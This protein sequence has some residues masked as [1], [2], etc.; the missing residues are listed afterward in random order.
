M[1]SPGFEQWLDDDSNPTANLDNGEEEDQDDVQIVD[2]G[3]FPNNGNFTGFIEIPLSPDSSNDV[4]YN[5]EDAPTGPSNGN[6]PCPDQDTDTNNDEDT[7]DDAPMVLLERSPSPL[8]IVNY[9]PTSSVSLSPSPPSPMIMTIDADDD[10]SELVNYSPSPPSS[11]PPSPIS[12]SPS[13][14]CSPLEIVQYSPTP[15]TS[16]SISPSP[17]PQKQSRS[18]SPPLDSS[19]KPGPSG[20]LSSIPGPSGFLTSKPGPSGFL[21]S[22]PGPSG[23]RPTTSKPGFFSKSGPSRNRSPR[24]VVEEIY[25]DASSSDQSV[26]SSPS[27]LGS[28]ISHPARC[29]QSHSSTILADDSDNSSDTRPVPR[30]KSRNRMPLP[31]R[32]MT[33]SPSPPPPMQSSPSPDS[34]AAPLSY[35]MSERDAENQG[36]SNSQRASNQQTRIS[37]SNRRGRVVESWHSPFRGIPKFKHRRLDPRRHRPLCRTDI[38]QPVIKLEQGNTPSST[39][40]AHR[41][42]LPNLSEILGE[43]IRCVAPVVPGTSTSDPPSSSFTAR[44]STSD[45][46]SSSFTARRARVTTT[47]LPQN[48][49]QT[50]VDSSSRSSHN[51]YVNGYLDRIANLQKMRR[52]AELNLHSPPHGEVVDLEDGDIVDLEE[53]EPADSNHNHENDADNHQSDTNAEYNFDMHIIG[54]Q[55][56]RNRICH[57]DPLEVM[58]RTRVSENENMERVAFRHRRFGIAA[59]SNAESARPGQSSAT[60]RNIQ[61][62]PQA[63]TGG[64]IQPVSNQQDSHPRIRFVDEINVI[65][66]TVS[67]INP[68]PRLALPRRVRNRVPTRDPETERPI[69]RILSSDPEPEIPIS[70]IQTERPI[71]RILSSDPEPEIPISRIQTERPILRIHSPGPE[72]ERPSSTLLSLPQRSLFQGS[73]SD[74]NQEVMPS[75]YS[76]VQLEQ[77]PTL[78]RLQYRPRESQTIG[79]HQFQ[80]NRAV[81]VARARN[82]PVASTE[83][84]STRIFR[85]HTLRARSIL[86]SSTENNA[87]NAVRSISNRARLPVRFNLN[88]STASTETSASDAGRS[89]NNTVRNTPVAS[90]EAI[91]SP[92]GSWCAKRRR[93]IANVSDRL[94]SMPVNEEAEL[95]PTIGDDDRAVTNEEGF[96]PHPSS[97]NQNSSDI[98]VVSSFSNNMVRV[99]DS[100]A[101]ESTTPNI[102]TS[103]STWSRSLV[104]PITSRSPS[105]V[106]GQRGPPLVARRSRIIPSPVEVQRP[107]PL[108][109]RILSSP[110]EVQRPPSLTARRSRRSSSPVEIE[111]PPP[112]TARRSRRSSSPVEFEGPGPL[113]ARWSRRSSSPAEFEDLPPDAVRRSRRSSGNL[114]VFEGPRP[115]SDR[116]SSSPVEVQRPPPLTAR[117]SSSPVEVEEP[118]PLSAIRSS[119]PVEVQRPPQL[120]ASSSRSRAVAEGSNVTVSFRNN[121]EQGLVLPCPGTSRRTSPVVVEYPGSPDMLDLPSRR[122]SSQRE[123]SSRESQESPSNS[124]HMEATSRESRGPRVGVQFPRMATWFR[125]SSVEDERHEDALTTSGMDRNAALNRGISNRPMRQIMQ[126]ANAISGSIDVMRRTTQPTTRSLSPLSRN[127]MERS[128]SPI[129][130]RPCITAERRRASRTVEPIASRTV[131]PIASR[132]VEPIAA[133]TAEPRSL[134]PRSENMMRRATQPTMGNQ[135]RFPRPL[136]GRAR[137]LEGRSRIARIVSPHPLSPRARVLEA[138][139][140]VERARASRTAEPISVPQPGDILP[141]GQTME[142]RARV[143][144]RQIQRDFQIGEFQPASLNVIE[145]IGPNEEIS[146]PSSGVERIDTLPTHEPIIEQGISNDMV[147]E[148]ADTSPV[149]EMGIRTIREDMGIR[150]RE[151][152]Q[153]LENLT[154]DD[155]TNN[156]RPRE[157][158]EVFQG[159]SVNGSYEADLAE[160]IKRSLEDPNQREDIR[161]E[162]DMEQSGTN[163]DSV[164][165]ET[166]EASPDGGREQSSGREAA[167]PSPGCSHWN[168]GAQEIVSSTSKP[169]G[170]DWQY[171]YNELLMKHLKLIADLQS[172]VE[173]PV[174]FE[175]PRSAPIPCCLMGHVM[176]STC[177]SRSQQCPT[178]RRDLPGKAP[179]SEMCVSHVANHLVD[180]L[181]HPC[182]NRDQG[183]PYEAHANEVTA[184]EADCEYR[185]IK[186]P[187]FRCKKQV[188]LKKLGEH[189]C[190]AKVP[191]HNQWSR[192]ETYP[193]QVTRRMNEDLIHSLDPVRFTFE[194]RPCFLQSMASDD[195]R[196]MFHFVQ[197]CGTREECQR[198]NAKIDIL[199]R[200]GLISSQ[201]CQLIPLDLHCLDDQ[202]MIGARLVMQDQAFLNMLNS[203]NQGGWTFKVNVKI[204]KT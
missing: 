81:E 72:T 149:Q 107:P 144:V 15:P 55:R 131:E 51:D 123:A 201:N 71:L 3:R 118:P 93:V 177:W 77:G 147:E 21:T 10:V 203:D 89:S 86:A 74:D 96:I 168:G 59:R 132:T 44:T 152:S 138:R 98:R 197:M 26:Q 172:S 33:P 99:R 41:T 42:F 11:I 25:S 102:G 34:D 12:P 129:E 186:C 164:L 69:L 58:R 68:R 75:M 187:S 92:N 65:P 200:G 204:S 45:P 180:L 195:S 112:L 14:V 150:I 193:L 76:P 61:E 31:H 160:A 36:Q 122:E 100:T 27:P 173:C 47:T 104:S 154:R 185:I 121:E 108:T 23:F 83:T 53:S 155:N 113:T 127:M 18:P 19:S 105:P 63:H 103:F 163:N 49:H 78:P 64:S 130:E 143:V 140:H 88:P 120:T 48:V 43:G 198:Y 24:Q 8:E 79:R 196:F 151:A 139:A 50:D 1:A 192:I 188:S 116:R 176:C 146:G 85:T 97:E 32:D 87:S 109:A 157:P 9:S 145:D 119:S 46:P 115:L 194:G 191:P 199:G 125:S 52:R 57:D 114:Q 101:S 181:P 124:E 184:H 170:P 117:R 38:S 182:T 37:M 13:P 137:V 202:D 183:C 60:P 190:S 20:F 141:L 110:V 134:S 169:P 128:L 136:V 70:R 159:G 16:I 165:D 82:T 35:N 174:C 67:D 17:P 90:T 167:S 6:E 189:I 40:A 111:R 56:P 91:A 178:C 30:M 106:F 54:S 39:E 171:K 22:K 66:S 4:V 142:E 126:R 156:E 28:P 158:R 7:D 94:D 62:S 175:I 133:R 2:V 80:S 153:L 135:T 5:C 148:L 73:S 161:E 179:N 95:I 162:E 29:P 166:R 84:T